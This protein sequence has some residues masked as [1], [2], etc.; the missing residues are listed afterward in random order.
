MKPGSRSVA[1]PGFATGEVDMVQVE[2]PRSVLLRL[3][4][5][6]SLVASELRSLNR[7]SRAAAREAVKACVLAQPP[8]RARLT[9][10][11]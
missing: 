11:E 9:G 6:R 4:R 8:P 1:A 3:L 5:E 2:I 7:R 10:I